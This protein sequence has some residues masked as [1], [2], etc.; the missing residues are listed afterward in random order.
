M[1]RVKNIENRI[2]GIQNDTDFE[3]LALE[4]FDF[5]SENCEVYK[6][7][8]SY[9]GKPK[10]KSIEAI[11]FL[12]ISFFKSHSINSFPDYEMV[13]SSS[14]TTG[15]TPSKHFVAHLDIYHQSMIKSFEKFYGNPDEYVLLALLPNYL[16]RE[17]S[18]LI[19]MMEKMIERNPHEE[20]GFFLYNHEEL[21]QRLQ[22]VELKGKKTILIGV[23]FALLDFF[24]KYSISLK[25][26]IIMETGGMKGRRK[27]I[28]REELHH[29]LIEK[30]GVQYIHS[31]YGM[32]ELLSQAYSK[33]EGIFQTPTW[34]KLYPGDPDDPFSFSSKTYG[35]IKIIDLANLYSCSFL[36][37]DDLGRFHDTNKKFEVIGRIDFSDVRGC[38]LLIF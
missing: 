35:T 16:E 36:Q 2:F 26:T 5:Q 29:F 20:S 10:P 3:E 9:L 32:T 33:G 37:T 11:P 18:S 12:P 8:L 31:E 22:E 34:M 7:F 6:R 14:G 19:Y 23:S 13:F 27:E 30:T 25:N 17:G 1:K 24:E 38:N 28:T 21:F 4:V 15:M